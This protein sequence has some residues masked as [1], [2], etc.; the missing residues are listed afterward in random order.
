M[1]CAAPLLLLLLAPVAL[2][3]SAASD[4]AEFMR[5]QAALKPDDFQ[6]RLDLATWAKRRELWSQAAEVCHE[7]LALQPDSRTAYALLAE[8]DQNLT[9]PEDKAVEE[10]L[11]AE[12]K[13]RHK[14]DF[15]I[16]NT[17]HFLIIYDTP[18][19]FAVERGATLERA[20][21]N[22][23]FNL[24]FKSL[25]PQFLKTRLVVVLFKNR[26][27]Y[28]AY[29]KAADAADLSWSSG[30]YSQRTNRTAFYDDATSPEKTKLADNLDKARAELKK[31]N[32]DIRKADLAGQKGL[33]NTLTAER[34]KL[35]DAITQATARMSNHATLNNNATTMHE[36]IHQL[37]FNMAIQKR[38][39]DYP[40][41]LTEGL[42]S[43][44]EYR[45][46]NNRAGPYLINPG[47]MAIVKD[48]LKK[49]ELIP[50]EKLLTHNFAIDQNLDEKTLH[51]IYAQGWALT[52]YLFRFHRDSLESYLQA[53]LD[54]R[55]MRAMTPERRRDMFTKSFGDL[56]K[57]QARFL[58]YLKDAPTRSP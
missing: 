34:N 18:E 3:D 9:L 50:L 11:L 24:H 7:A 16:R 12:F 30:Y 26:E 37:A 42:A 31:L 33:V 5:R 6:A 48:A 52:H 39:V 46:Q 23:I 57:L 28:L 36:A 41:W 40:L 29:A 38:L 13:E 1:R 25:R 55:I 15:K 58:D 44:F 19:A 43:A 56:D 35:A 4:L 2:A 22:F 45:D 21:E 27:D 8:C 32:D 47:R 54:D 14:R 17:R 20:Y 51:L 10:K 53:H 49:D